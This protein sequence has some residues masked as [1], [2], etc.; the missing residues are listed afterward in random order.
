MADKLLWIKIWH[1]F[2]GIL[3]VILIITGLHMQYS[4]SSLSFLSFHTSVEIHNIS[5]ILLTLSFLA[6][7][8]GN[9]IS[10][11]SKNYKIK[12]EELT[13]DFWVQARYYAFGVFKGEKEPYPTGKDREFNPLQ[14]ASYTFVMYI[15][16]PIIIITGLAM[17][18]PE[19]IIDR[20]VGFKG[21]F[22]TDILHVVISFIISMFLIV[23]LY[24]A[25]F[26]GFN[27]KH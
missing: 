23:H 14:K 21:F 3:C 27:K 2:N 12:R 20:I 5:G 15:L 13:R 11:N 6:F 8:T 25:Y 18:F 10:R 7:I 16:M 22:L 26:H 1:W 19:I 24:F 9:I 4:G 17:L